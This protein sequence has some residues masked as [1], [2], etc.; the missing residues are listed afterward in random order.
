MANSKIVK[1]ILAGIVGL[2]IEERLL[3]V[4]ILAIIKQLPAKM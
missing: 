4:L 3:M 2:A 1:K